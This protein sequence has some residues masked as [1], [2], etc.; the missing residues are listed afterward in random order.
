[1]TNCIYVKGTRYR[2]KLIKESNEFEG[3]SDYQKRLITIV[4]NDNNNELKRAIIHELLH[5]FFYECGL[6]FYKN[7]ETLVYFLESISKDLHKKTNQ[8]FKFLKSKK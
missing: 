7:D 1:M 2:I 3:Q 4:K 5:V 8:V 6:P